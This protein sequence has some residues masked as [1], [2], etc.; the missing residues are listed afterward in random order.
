M[1]GATIFAEAHV[2]E[3]DKQKAPVADGDGDG[4]GDGDERAI[5]AG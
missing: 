4:D 3:I 1:G 5:D 2:F